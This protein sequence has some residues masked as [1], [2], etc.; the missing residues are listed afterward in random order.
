MLKERRRRKIHEQILL[1]TREAKAASAEIL[2]KDSEL[3]AEARTVEQQ[4]RL[5]LC[6]KLYGTLPRELRD[7]VYDY[8]LGAARDEVVSRK[9]SVTW[10]GT[11]TVFDEMS[12]PQQC[13]WELR[14]TEPGDFFWWRDD[15]MGAQVALE[16]VERW[17][18][19]RTL[20]IRARH[21]KMFRN[22]LHYDLFGTVLKPL[23]AINSITILIT[24]PAATKAEAFH[25][26]LRHLHQ[27][28]NKSASL[29]LKLRMADGKVP[30]Y[31][32][33]MRQFL[34]FV[35]PAVFQLREHGF[36]NVSVSSESPARVYT[37]LYDLTESE[38]NNV[39]VSRRCD[40]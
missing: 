2:D 11:R 26:Q 7:M 29:S 12:H 18:K 3:L 34:Q 6:T 10:E 38:I 17:Y 39:L 33:R 16:V 8:V 25:Q 20:V 40:K 19:T 28:D 30:N 1:L 14:T 4:D 31:T 36:H 9:Y 15:H 22:L 37:P 21:K 32:T 5:A 35:G 23:S 24:S 13:L 27:I